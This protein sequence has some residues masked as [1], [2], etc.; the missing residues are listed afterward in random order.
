MR[1]LAL[2][3]GG[4]TELPDFLVA[5]DLAAGRLVHVLPEW[6]LS[7]GGIYAIYP[8]RKHLPARVRLFISLLREQFGAAPAFSMCRRLV[9]QGCHPGF[10]T[11]GKPTTRASRKGWTSF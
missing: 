9:C 1:N 3:G 8:S 11:S 6:N 4:V 5:D 2:A 10:G 7:A